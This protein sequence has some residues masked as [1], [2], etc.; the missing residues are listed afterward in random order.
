MGGLSF[1]IDK[2]ESFS[3]DNGTTVRGSDKQHRPIS[4]GRTPAQPAYARPIP[5]AKHPTEF[6]PISASTIPPIGINGCEKL[7]ND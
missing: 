3:I 7:V 6:L 5:R 4:L 1:G 2:N